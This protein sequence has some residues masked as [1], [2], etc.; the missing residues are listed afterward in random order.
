MEQVA[1]YVRDG[2]IQTRWGACERG[3][4]VLAVGDLNAVPGSPVHA[5]LLA[6]GLRDAAELSGIYGATWPAAGSWGKVPVF[7]LDHVL[8]GGIEVGPVRTFRQPDSDHM[9]LLTEV[10]IDG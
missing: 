5:R 6:M 9:A 1:A 7:R 8:S 10:V 3:D 4:R 2:R